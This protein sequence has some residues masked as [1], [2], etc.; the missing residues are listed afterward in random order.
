MTQLCGPGG[1]PKTPAMGSIAAVRQRARVADEHSLV[2]YPNGTVVVINFAVRVNFGITFAVSLFP[3]ST[4]RSSA[5]STLLANALAI[6]Q[7]VE[8]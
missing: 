2:S 4:S 5:G 7:K 3:F 1:P 6:R 8:G